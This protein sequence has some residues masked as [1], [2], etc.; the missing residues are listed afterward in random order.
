MTRDLTAARAAAAFCVLACLQVA[1]NLGW[2]ESHTLRSPPT[3]DPANY[4]R[5]SLLYLTAW[6]GSGAPGLAGAVMDGSPYL[7]PLLPLSSVPLYL[8]FGPTRLAAHLATGLYLVLFLAGGFLLAARRGGPRAALLAAFLLGSFT[9]TLNLSRDYQMDFPAAALLTLALV[10]LDRS[11]GLSRAVF[12]AAFG[13]FAGLALVAKTVSGVF[14]AGPLLWTVRDARLRKRRWL[15]VLVGLSIAA[16]AAAAVAG[17]WWLRHGPAVLLYVGQH[18]FGAG[19]A[20]YNPTGRQVDFSYYA[21]ALFNDGVGPPLAALLL[22]VAVVSLLPR[23][24]D[25]AGEPRRDGLLWCWVVTGYVALSL[26]PNRAGERYTAA[27]LPPIA[28]L[29]AAAIVRVPG[30]AARRGLLAAALVLGSWNIASWTWSLP[31]RSQIAVWPPR[32]A[33]VYR[34]GP[35]WLRNPLPLPL[36]DWPTRDL[37]DRLAGA[38]AT[39][40]DAGAARARAQGAVPDPGSA[41]EQVH[42]AYRHVLRRPAEPFQ[43]AADADALAYGVLSPASLVERLLASD[44]WRLRSLQVLVLP[45]HPFVNAATLNYYAVLDGRPLLF[46]R[47]GDRPVSREELDAYDVVVAKAGGYQGP[48]RSTAGNDALLQW[49]RSAGS[50]F[51]RLDG[52]FSCPDDSVLEL[53]APAPPAASLGL[54][55]ERAGVGPRVQGLAAVPA[56]PL[57]GDLAGLEPL[58]DVVELGGLVVDVAGGGQILQDLRRPLVSLAQV[59]GDGLHHDVGD[60]L[61]D[62]A[63]AHAGRGAAPLR[64]QPLDL[65]RVGAEVGKGAREH[66]VQHH[67]HRV[68]VRGQ[69]RASGELLGGH[70][71]R[72]ADHGRGVALLEQAAGAEV[73]HLEHAALRQ[74]DVGRAQV[75]VE[76]LRLVRV[77]HPL[78]DLDDV[79]RGAR[80]VQALLAVEHGL[81]ALALDVVHHDEEDALHPLR[82]QDADDVGV[83]EGGQEARLLEEVVEVPALAVGDL[84]GHL[85]VDPGVLGEVDRPEPAGAQVRED[86]ILPDS[87]SQQEHEAAGSI[88]SGPIPRVRL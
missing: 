1:L 24:R 18:G 62:V 52:T 43:A 47:D 58:A 88:A 13:A 48:S 60:L 53:Y 75:A 3:W 20:P 8:L 31:F 81:Q 41:E 5:L 40:L 84:D 66:L 82:G 56:E 76:D 85:L 15:D 10:A 69:H 21:L 19:S 14:L 54:A 37:S 6:R 59:R 70:V 74:Q 34:P 51:R 63:V 12:V 65:R 28:A 77:L 73:G 39:I 80:H 32:R 2:L 29:A 87:L 72:A 11:R 27:L 7:A 67:A 46:V 55:A 83:V 22:A 44:E 57:L 35:V 38:R 25:S 26:V 16:G 49:L 42:A 79:V 61:G 64:H 23:A 17:P 50:G 9:A 86:L 71:G 36:I 78:Q 33:I 4:Q 68:D 30:A 45:D